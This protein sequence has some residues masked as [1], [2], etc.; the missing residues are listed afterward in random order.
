MNIGPNPETI[1]AAEYGTWLMQTL[2]AMDDGPELD[3]LQAQFDNLINTLVSLEKSYNLP[4]YE[5]N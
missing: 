3:R 1:T 2:T 4:S 5:A